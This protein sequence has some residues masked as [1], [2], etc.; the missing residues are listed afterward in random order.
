MYLL[1]AS[2]IVS[3]LAVSTRFYEEILGFQRDSR[4]ELG[5]S[6]VFYSLGQ[7]QQLHLMQVEDP[8]LHCTRPQHGGRDR[9]L[10]FAVVA[11]LILMC[12]N[13]VKSLNQ[14]LE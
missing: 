10:A 11:T 3:D 12:W 4:P 1:H 2:L 13:F 5:F 7:G 14:K 8:Y 9:H 6:G